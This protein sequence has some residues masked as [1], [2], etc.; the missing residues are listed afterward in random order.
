MFGYTGSE[1]ADKPV[2]VLIPERFANKH[3][4]FRNMFLNAPQ[5]RSM[6]AGRELFALRKDKTEFPVEIGLNS[7]AAA[8]DDLV[9]ASIIDISERLCCMKT[10]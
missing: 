3:L 7:F 1:L 8:D 9:L 2:E 10:T 5:T 6:G 4:S